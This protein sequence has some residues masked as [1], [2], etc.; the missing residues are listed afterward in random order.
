[1]LDSGYRQVSQWMR[2]KVP[3]P[4]KPKMVVAFE[5]AVPCLVRDSLGNVEGGIR[6][7]LLTVPIAWYEG[8]VG[9]S[10]LTHP[11]NATLLR[12]LYPT[13]S[14]YVAKVAVASQASLIDGDILSYQAEDYIEQALAANVPP[15]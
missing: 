12:S 11:F 9:A 7:P 3:P 5:G 8:F 6:L 1:V 10:G 13:H 2:T 15:S 4:S 14:D